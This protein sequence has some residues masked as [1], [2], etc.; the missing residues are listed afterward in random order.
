MRPGDPVIRS[1]GNAAAEHDGT[2]DIFEIL[3]SDGRI[4]EVP[5]RRE[6][7]HWPESCRRWR[8]ETEAVDTPTGRSDEPETSPCST[9][10]ASSGVDVIEL[11]VMR[12]MRSPLQRELDN[13]SAELTT[14]P[15]YLRGK[16]LAK[17]SR[18]SL[19]LGA[20]KLRTRLKAVEDEI[21]KRSEFSDLFETYDEG[22]I[23]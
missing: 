4:I 6:W 3:L 16:A 2:R 9:A 17:F 15:S 13:A 5:T 23:A 19:E 12:P 22:G 1:E 11:K 18:R 10:S 20:R 21:A 8:T 14:L 7:L